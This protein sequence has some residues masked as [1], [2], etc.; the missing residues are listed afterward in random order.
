M[1]NQSSFEKVKSTLPL[2]GRGDLNIKRKGNLII[3]ISGS[4]KAFK[5]ELP[6]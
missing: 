6:L 2:Y 4:I 5:V 1:K 3:K